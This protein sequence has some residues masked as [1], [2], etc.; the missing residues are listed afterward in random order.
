MLYEEFDPAII[1]FQQ[2][3][4]YDVNNTFDYSKGT[5]EILLSGAIGSAKTTLMA[6]L[7][8]DHCFKYKRARVLIGRLSM[9]E[10]KE[11]LFN[12]I[13]DMIPEDWEEGREYRVNE[14]KA[15]ISFCNGS[16]IISR[17]WSDRR[18]KKVRSLNLTAAFIEEL[19][20]NEDL[21][22]YH[23][24]KLRVGR[25]NEIPEKLIVC[26]T[27]P[28]SPAHE[29]YEYFIKSK[30]PTRHVYYSKTRDNKTLPASY[31]EQLERQLDPKMAKRMLDGLWI[32]IFAE[33]IYYEYT[34][35]IHD[36]SG[37]HKID[38]SLPII[39][40]FDFNIAVGKPMSLIAMHQDQDGIYHAFDEIVIEGFRTM[41]IMEEVQDRDW[42]GGHICLCGDATGRHRDTRSKR[43][44]WEII[45]KFMADHD[46]ITYEMQVPRSNPPIRTRHNK[47]NAYL[48]NSLGETRLY[49][50]D[51]CEKA[52]EGL[53]KTAFKRGSTT[54][55]DDTK[56][57]QHITTAIGYAIWQRER[58]LRAGQQRTVQL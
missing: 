4:I 32:E 46:D 24:I 44:D 22:F 20:E 37:E 54:V 30:F 19:T 28:D 9:P 16:R 25:N 53:L 17:S 10:L 56:D 58:V 35:K 21:E 29:A 55:E 11:T 5:H 14:T 34:P 26:A 52:R 2:Q 49:L 39:I 43:S 40:S 18:Y 47:V 45:E 13:L 1:P 8:L 27:N 6:F 57:Y 42:F 38:Q 41:D 31:V 36:K 50:Y 51:K 3:V 33:T 23:E 15:Q 12:E 7:A 48:M